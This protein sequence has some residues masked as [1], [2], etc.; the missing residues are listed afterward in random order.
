MPG[1]SLCCVVSFSET[2][3]STLGSKDTHSS[4]H[5]ALANML[6]A[7]GNR[8]STLPQVIC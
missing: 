6:G 3:G 1:N 7:F 4:G 2:V 5:V 8:F